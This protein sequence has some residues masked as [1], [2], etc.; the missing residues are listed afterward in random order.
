[1]LYGKHITT[2]SGTYSI[3]KLIVEIWFGMELVSKEYL[4]TLFELYGWKYYGLQW[5]KKEIDSAMWL[6]HR[7]RFW[8]NDC[9]TS[10]VLELLE[11][12][13]MEKWRTNKVDEDGDFTGKIVVTK[14]LKGYDRGVRI[15]FNPNK[16]LNHVIVKKFFDWYNTISNQALI[17]FEINMAPQWRWRRVD[18]AFDVPDCMDNLVLLSRKEEAYQYTTRYYGRRGKNGHTRMYDKKEEVNR[19]SFGEKLTEPLTRFEWEQHNEQDITFDK[20]LRL[21]EIPGKLQWLRFIKLGELNAC[22]KT[23]DKRTAKKVKENCFQEIPFDTSNFEKLLQE[24]QQEFGL[25][26]NRHFVTF[27]EYS[28]MSSDEKADWSE[29]MA[30]DWGATR[31]E[32]W[33]KLNGIASCAGADTVPDDGLPDTEDLE[34][35]FYNTKPARE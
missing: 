20:P 31:A 7:Y 6:T 15:Q 23:L 30:A 11:R 35:E 1:M 17:K 12:K 21:G 16:H 33:D 18:Y 32:M 13:V 26:D 25:P 22:L 9:D 2:D 29:V 28:K 27:G 24:Y 34:R 4:S 19:H 8:Q 5:E 3:D 10:V 14:R